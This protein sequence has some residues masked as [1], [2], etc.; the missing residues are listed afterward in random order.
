M[1]LSV[2]T[3]VISHVIKH[4]SPCKIKE[5]HM[6]ECLLPFLGIQFRLI[7]PSKV[8]LEGFSSDLRTAFKQEHLFLDTTYPIFTREMAQL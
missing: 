5:S 8:Y 4:Y 7:S 1:L 3:F 2:A 6:E